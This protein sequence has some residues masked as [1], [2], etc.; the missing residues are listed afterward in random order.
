M[1]TQEYLKSRLRYDPETGHFYWV[2][3]HRSW[4]NGNRAGCYNSSGGYVMITFDNEKYYGHRLAWLYVHGYMPHEIDHINRIRNDNR[5]ANLRSCSR[6]Q[7]LMN[8][9]DRKRKT[10]LPRGVRKAKNKYQAHI[11]QMGKAIYIGSFKSAELA[12]AAY[13]KKRIEIFGE[14]A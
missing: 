3:C 2:N 12:S 14:F 1:L 10:N 8:G 9:V 11:Y 4:R 5:I 13:R 7:N 6:S